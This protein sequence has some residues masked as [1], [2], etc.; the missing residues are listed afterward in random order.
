LSKN[1]E[2]GIFR[3]FGRPQSFEPSVAFQAEVVDAEAVFLGVDQAGNPETQGLQGPLV[4]AAFKDLVLHPLSEVFQDMGEP[5]TP[6]VVRN[7]I[8]H[9][10]Q[11][12]NRKGSY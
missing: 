12:G 1:V 8:R 11:H 7:I 3:T 6:A 9:D 4:E 10:D 5:G 2:I